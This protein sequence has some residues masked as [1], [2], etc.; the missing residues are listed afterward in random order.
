MIVPAAFTIPENRQLPRLPGSGSELR[1]A[2]RAWDARQTL[3]LTGSAATRANLLA[4]VASRPEVLHIA[5]HVL[6]P[7]ARPDDALLDFGVDSHGSPSV[8][9][10]DD[11][12]SLGLPDS[13]IVMSGCASAADD[14]SRG[15][16]PGGLT[17]AWFLAGARAVV[18]TR[19]PTSDGNGALFESFYRALRITRRTGARG[20]ASRAMQLAA[21]EMLHSSSWKS[22]P[23]YWAAF[24]V[25]EKE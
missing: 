1:R 18:G 15:S 25:I 19:R 23:S 3:L 16:G 14:D 11:I 24:Y 20:A 13:V 5:T 22:V 7:S 6:H 4:A 2:A 12:A 8:L 9:S 10:T 21:L 17:W